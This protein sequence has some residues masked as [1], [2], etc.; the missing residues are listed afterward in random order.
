LAPLAPDIAGEDRRIAG[1][2]AGG[3]IETR[4]KRAGLVEGGVS[5]GDRFP[6]GNDGQREPSPVAG[7]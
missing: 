7:R 4:R 5:R 3:E 6:I 1:G 2:R